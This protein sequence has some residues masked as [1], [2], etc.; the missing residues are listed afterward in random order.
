MKPKMSMIEAIT[1]H[2]REKHYNDICKRCAHSWDDS[3]EG[4]NC[5]KYEATVT[6]SSGAEIL[7]HGQ[8]CDKAYEN[9]CRGNGFEPATFGF[10][11]AAPPSVQLFILAVVIPALIDT[12]VMFL[13][14]LCRG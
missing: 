7:W 6:L 5:K 13:F 8:A 14:F 2:S 12:V 10:F 9:D 3:I 4:W 11:K 1:E